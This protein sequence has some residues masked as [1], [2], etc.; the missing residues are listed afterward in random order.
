MKPH[1]SETMDQD[2]VAHLG[3]RGQGRYE[4][5]GHS[6]KGIR[7]RSVMTVLALIAV[8]LA[9]CT[10][11]NPLVPEPY[12]RT[13]NSLRY[14]WCE[15]A[16]NSFR[17]GR[18]QPVGGRPGPVTTSEANCILKVAYVDPRTNRDFQIFNLASVDDDG[19]MM[20]G[21]Q[22]PFSGAFSPG[23][24]SPSEVGEL[25]SL[26][27]GLPNSH[28]FIPRG[29]A[30]VVGFSKNDQWETRVYDKRRLPSGLIRI[31]DITRF[32]IE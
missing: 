14:G 23:T 20:H 28:W 32:T 6:V 13:V 30:I 5:G 22:R 27:A 25:G 8:S 3:G 21:C 24:C 9:I 19:I 17:H 15:H 7:L 4:L 29:D 18:H 10:G 31:L 1:E 2:R 12:W 26:V 11:H 16:R